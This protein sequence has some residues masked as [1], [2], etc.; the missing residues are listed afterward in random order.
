MLQQ[1]GLH[2]K[3]GTQPWGDDLHAFSGIHRGV[4]R[5][6]LTHQRP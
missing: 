2:K 4:R 1:Q 5:P 3:L 6:I